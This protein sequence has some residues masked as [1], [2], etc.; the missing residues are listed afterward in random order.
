MALG[1][2]PLFDQTAK[3]TVRLTNKSSP[4]ASQPKGAS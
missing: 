4:L 2:P 1:Q 3:R